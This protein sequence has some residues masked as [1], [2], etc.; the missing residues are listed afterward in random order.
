[1]MHPIWAEEM[2]DMVNLFERRGL[3][4]RPPPLTTEQA[5]AFHQSSV[6]EYEK[7]KKRASRAKRAFKKQNIHE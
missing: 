2:R 4:T 6:R 3:I 5:L 7:A 1:M